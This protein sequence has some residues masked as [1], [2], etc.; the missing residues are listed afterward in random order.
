MSKKGK[1]ITTWGIK[2]NCGISTISIIIAMKLSKL[3]SNKKILW[4]TTNQYFSIAKRSLSIDRCSYK[5]SIDTII[6]HSDNL[7]NEKLLEEA[8]VNIKNY[9]NLYFLLESNSK[10]KDFI[11]EN[12]KN[13]SKIVFPKLKE[14]FDLIVIDTSSFVKSETT[15]YLFNN[16]DIIINVITQNSISISEYLFYKNDLN[17]ITKDRINLI[18]FYRSNVQPGFEDIEDDL[19]EEVLKLAYDS[20]IV[21]SCNT[22]NLEKYISEEF[23]EA[24]EDIEKLIYEI[25]QRLGINYNTKKNN[26]KSLLKFVKGVLHIGK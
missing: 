2:K 10:S 11:K 9:D 19:G 23:N 21:N 16:S 25:I 13:F 5:N 1:V 12:L 14:E 24:S 22:G 6:D 26:Q 18:N 3:F 7:D 8:L 15:K 4:L 20:M 17:K